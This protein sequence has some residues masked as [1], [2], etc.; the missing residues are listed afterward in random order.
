MKNAI[1]F[2]MF[3]LFC[4]TS[5]AY[6]QDQKVASTAQVTGGNVDDPDTEVAKRRF[7]KGVAHYDSKRYQEALN[8]FLAA[9]VRKPMPE[10]DFNIGRCYDRLEQYDA[11][12]TAYQGFLEQKPNTP[13]AADIKERI[14]VLKERIEK[15][16]PETPAKPSPEILAPTVPTP[17][18]QKRPSRLP[19]AAPAALAG[20]A[21]AGF[22]SGM[23]LT[24]QGKGIVDGLD[25]TC[26]RPCYDS[27]LDTATIYRD[28]GYALLAVSGVAAAASAGLWAWWGIQ[29]KN[30]PVVGLFPLSGGAGFTVGV[31]LE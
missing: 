7:Q 29:R 16:K 10:F 25:I 12:I 3:V 1:R 21:V 5:L 13:D 2:V 14:R 31:P 24:F 8:E 6:A 27:S 9:K 15:P 19:V 18:P 30:R 26:A 4:F 22:V 11:A 17:L 23:V 28:V 20:L